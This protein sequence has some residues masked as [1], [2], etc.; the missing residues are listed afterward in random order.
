MLPDRIAELLGRLGKG[1]FQGVATDVMGRPVSSTDPLNQYNIGPANTPG[2]QLAN[3][4]VERATAA[5]VLPK[6]IG[7]VVKPKP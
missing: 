6:E 1:D 5:G 2:E 7:G 4:L 3:L